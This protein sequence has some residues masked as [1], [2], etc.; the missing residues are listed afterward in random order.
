MASAEPAKINSVHSVETIFGD[1][2]I[3]FSDIEAALES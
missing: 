1:I 2:S 3:N